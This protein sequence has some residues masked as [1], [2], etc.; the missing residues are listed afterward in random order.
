MATS[1]TNGQGSALAVND[2]IKILETNFTSLR[3]VMIDELCALR[4]DLDTVRLGHWKV[5]LGP[6]VHATEQGAAAGIALRHQLTDKLGVPESSV[7]LTITSHLHNGDDSSTIGE[8]GVK[9][10]QAMSKAILYVF[11]ISN[12]FVLSLTHSSHPNAETQT[13]ASTEMTSKVSQTASNGVAIAIPTFQIPAQNKGEWKPCSIRNLLP[14]VGLDIPAPS[15]TVTFSHDFL[16]AAFNGVEW[17]PGLFFTPISAGQCILPSRTYYAI[18]ATYEPYLPDKPG[19]HGAKL[20]AFFNNVESTDGT[21]A[22]ENVPLFISAAKGGATRF[23]E[24]QYVYF[25]TYSQ[26]R[27]SD[28]LDYDRIRDCVPDE[29]KRYWAEQLADPARPQWVTQALMRQFVP[30]PEYDGIL[31]NSVA[32]GSLPSGED[33]GAQMDKD[34]RS[35]IKELQYWEKDA[36]LQVSLLKSDNIL[37]AF[38][39]VSPTYATF[40]PL[41]EAEKSNRLMLPKSP[42]CACGGSTLSVL[43][44]TPNSTTCSSS[45]KRRPRTS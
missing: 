15:K 21:A 8:N 40:S 23:A 22:Y 24:N 39:N 2:D 11:V 13:T 26:K 36:R 32:N 17:S 20:T 33:L 6:F 3:G 43:A 9:T 30:M 10:K 35:F 45:Y 28:K 25:G 18:N 14:L 31:P 7:P 19:S 41:N 4:R 44:G 42:A 34:V 37:E 27:W 38:N 12:T 5:D 16:Q 1:V 29:T